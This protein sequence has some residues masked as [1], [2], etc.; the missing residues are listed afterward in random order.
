MKALNL[1]SK[2]EDS[3]RDIGALRRTGGKPHSL[4]QIRCDRPSD[5]R[6]GNGLN[7]K[8]EARPRPFYFVFDLYVGAGLVFA[9]SIIF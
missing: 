6:C 8:T 5:R 7:A 1:M 2:F 3:T 4:C 9:P